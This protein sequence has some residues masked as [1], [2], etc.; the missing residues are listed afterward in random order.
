MQSLFEYLYSGESR[1]GESAAWFIRWGIAAFFLGNSLFQKNLYIFLIALTLALYN[2]LYNVLKRIKHTGLFS[3]SSVITETLAVSLGIFFSSRGDFLLFSATSPLLWMY[4]ILLYSASLRLNE[5]LI[6]FSSVLNITGMNSV[7][8]IRYISNPRHFDT[9]FSGACLSDQ[10]LR[11]LFLMALGLLLLNRPRIIRRI[12]KNQ[13]D[14]F[15]KMKQTNFSSQEQLERLTRDASLTVREEEVLRELLKGKTYRMIGDSL[16]ISV[17]TAKSHIKKLY[18]KLG[19]SS[20]NELYS[21]IQENSMME[22]NN[23]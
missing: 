4:F 16:C 2:L 1:R 17:D 23:R 20:R 9:A 18:R 12:L 22:G 10:V 7:Y 11:T 15:D 13:Q 8:L 3:Y 6:L 21:L 14:F 19:I 5:K